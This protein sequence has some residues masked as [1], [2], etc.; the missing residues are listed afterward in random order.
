ML[1]DDFIGFGYANP[2]I[3]LL[4]LASPQKTILHNAY[5]SSIWEY[6]FSTVFIT[7]GKNGP[8]TI[9]DTA[10]EPLLLNSFG[11]NLI[12]YCAYS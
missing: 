4:A 9:K 2:S 3:L 6:D 5:D 12:E 10:I 7:T 1:S 8:S 11:R